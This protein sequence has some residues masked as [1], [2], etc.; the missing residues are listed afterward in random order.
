[1]LGFIYA[2]FF[3]LFYPIL[4][5]ADALL[6]ADEVFHANAIIDWLKG[7]PF[8]LYYEGV[9]YHGIVGGLSA[10]PFF[11]MLG[12]TA[13]AFKMAGLLY[14]SLYIWTFYLIGRHF[15]RSV[16]YILLFLLLISPAHLAHIATINVPFSV[17]GF[18]GNLIFLFFNPWIYIPL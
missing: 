7:G 13:M 5:N 1:M 11:W 16:G 17:I 6:N 8:F 4:F 10:V 9:F 18:F 15:G 12:I 14:Y 3:L 2:Y